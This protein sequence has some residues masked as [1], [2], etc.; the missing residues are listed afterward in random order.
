MRIA[1]ACGYDVGKISTGC[2]VFSISLVSNFSSSDLKKINFIV[3]NHPMWTP[4]GLYEMTC[5]VL[6]GTLS[7]YATTK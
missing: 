3:L 5:N 2:L 1:L 6:S 7:L 4:A